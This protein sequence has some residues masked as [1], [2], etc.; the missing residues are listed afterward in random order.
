MA[1]IVHKQLSFDIIGCAQKVHSVLGPGFPESVY[2]RA[3][4]VELAKAKIPFE[5]EKSV[6]VWYEEHLCGTFR[7]DIVVDEKVVL[8]LKALNGLADD[9][10]AQALSYLKAT[11]LNL[12]IVLNFGCKSL[13]T[14]RVVL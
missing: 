11:G 7:M 9:H 3:L 10:L 2:H 5:S 6:E 4:C 14:K 1:E 12:A 13:N 8:E